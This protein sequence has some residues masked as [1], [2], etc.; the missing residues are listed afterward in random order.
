[1]LILALLGVMVLNQCRTILPN[2]T[3]VTFAVG[4]PL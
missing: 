4:W 2:A 3:G 1:M